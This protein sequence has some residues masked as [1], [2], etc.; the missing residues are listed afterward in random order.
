MNDW[1]AFEE[2][3]YAVANAYL[4]SPEENAVRLAEPVLEVYTARSG[5]RQMKGYG[6]VMNTALVD[7][8]EDGDRIDLL[9][10]LGSDFR[11]LMKDPL[12]QGGKVFSPN[13][14]SLL[15]FYPRMPWS[16]LSVG[17]FEMRVKRLTLL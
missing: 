3:R 8:H 7:L 6:L 1:V 5:K 4:T 9:L 12:L 15:H 17:D 14:R 13:V 10:D 16:P 11:F 2:G